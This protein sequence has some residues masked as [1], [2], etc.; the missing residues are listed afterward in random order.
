MYSRRAKRISETMRKEISS[1]IVQDLCDP[2]VSFV[3]VTNVQVSSD[4]KKARVLVSMLG[5]NTTQKTSLYGLRSARSYI[6]GQLARR[7]NMRYTPIISFHLDDSLKKMAHI[8]ELI[9][10]LNSGDAEDVND[11]YDDEDDWET[12]KV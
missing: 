5:D 2:R 11:V 12:D 8:N 7:M 6:Q 10:G 3:T 4:M 1:I 9:H